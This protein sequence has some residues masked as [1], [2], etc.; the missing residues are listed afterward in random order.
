MDEEENLTL[1]SILREVT[2]ARTESANEMAYL[3]RKVHTIDNSVKQVNKTVARSVKREAAELA[4]EIWDLLEHC[5]SKHEDRHL[6]ISKD[7]LEHV[8]NVMRDKE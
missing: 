6:L 7:Q 8:L 2:T 5:A 3:R 4:T 1:K